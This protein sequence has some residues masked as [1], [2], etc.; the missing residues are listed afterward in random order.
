MGTETPLTTGL[1]EPF[2]QVQ[3]LPDS[4]V[5]AELVHGSIETIAVF[6]NAMPSRLA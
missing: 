5:I 4:R 1:L 6:H 3:Q 2:V